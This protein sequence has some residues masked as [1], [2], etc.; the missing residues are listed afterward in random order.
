[1]KRLAAM[2][3]ALAALVAPTLAAEETVPQGYAFDRPELLADQMIWGL[4]HGARLLALDCAQAGHGAAA[5]AWADWQERE[6]ASIRAAG[7]ALGR[8]YFGRPDVPVEV[9]SA[10][11]GLRPRLDLA[12]KRLAPACASLPAALAQP[13]YDLKHRRA[14]W[15]KR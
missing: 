7:E 14:E 9:L 8:H 12:P 11:L 2:G 10:A 4:V 5:E 1:M 13:R 15:L 3:G 6:R